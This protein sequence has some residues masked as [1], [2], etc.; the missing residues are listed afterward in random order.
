MSVELDPAELGFR[1]PF[2]REVTETL[3]LINNNSSPVAFKASCQDNRAKTILFLLQAMK[4]EPPLD[5]K[6]RDKFLVQS[7]LTSPDQDPNVTTLWQQVEKT[8]KSS[9]S[10]KKIR[11][12]FLPAIGAST[13]GTL[14]SSSHPGEE[15]PPAYSSPSPQFGSPAPVASSSTP[16][17]NSSSELGRGGSSSVAEATGITAATAAISRSIP[18]SNEELQEQLAAAKAQIQKLSAQVQDPQFRQRKAQQASEKVQTV[19]Q[20][21][22]ESGVPLQIVAGLCLLSFLI[23]YLFF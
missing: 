6:C 5:S 22:N 14:S 4:E 1:R 8:A 15:Q 20:Q 9:I 16:A 3:K 2:D 13:N 11:V 7:V 23:A 21:S 12:N 17:K 10:E 18:T 19:V